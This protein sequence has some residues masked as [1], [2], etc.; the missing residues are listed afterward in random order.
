MKLPTR[1]QVGFFSLE[2][3]CGFFLA[4]VLFPN[5]LWTK[6]NPRSMNISQPTRAWGADKNPW[7][8]TTDYIM[9]KVS[10]RKRGLWEVGVNLKW[11]DPLGERLSETAWL[12]AAW[13]VSAGQMGWRG[14]P[15]K[16]QKNKAPIHMHVRA[17]PRTG[18]HTW[19]P[20]TTGKGGR[21]KTLRLVPPA[22]KHITPTSHRHTLG[23]S[24]HSP[25]TGWRRMEVV[26]GGVDIACMLSLFKS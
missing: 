14:E 24:H 18:W 3:V 11:A 17:W 25:N 7:A 9:Q 26:R 13:L 12:L 23:A 16:K 8:L 5:P 10:G 1:S 19:K 6:L 15:K 21:S 4:R 22:S 2:G 20:R